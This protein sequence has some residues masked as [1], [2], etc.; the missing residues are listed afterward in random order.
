MVNRSDLF[1][2]AG[3]LSFHKLQ[4]KL[5]AARV[6]AYHIPSPKTGS[7]FL[8]YDVMTRDRFTFMASS[9]TEVRDG[10]QKRLKFLALNVGDILLSKNKKKKV[11]SRVWHLL[12]CC[13]EV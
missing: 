13:L 4:S 9:E 12:V 5:T 1:S 2:L 8:E 6:L 7:T 11:G 10:L 3:N